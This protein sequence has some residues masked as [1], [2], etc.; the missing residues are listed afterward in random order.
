LV[1]D[2]PDHFPDLR[3]VSHIG[4]A[5][6]GLHTEGGTFVPGFGGIFFRAGIVQGGL[7]S[8]A[9]QAERNSTANSGA[10][11]GN[12]GNLVIKHG[13]FLMCFRRRT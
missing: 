7:Y 8:A 2:S 10:A 11:T 6:D 12:Q 4:L 1:Y 5:G 3:V 9:G 13:H